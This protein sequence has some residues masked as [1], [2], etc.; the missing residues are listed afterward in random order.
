LGTND[1]MPPPAQHLLVNSARSRPALSRC[2]AAGLLAVLAAPASPAHADVNHGDQWRLRTPSITQTR[3]LTAAN[4]HAA[5]AA[6]IPPASDSASP[7]PDPGTGSSTPASPAATPK[8]ASTT[9][10]AVVAVLAVLAV[11]AS[12][13]IR[14]AASRYRRANR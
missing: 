5:R 4:P 14:R 2:A 12:T 1:D 11:L 10:Y 8:G 3:Q 13:W 9:G 6:E 7:K